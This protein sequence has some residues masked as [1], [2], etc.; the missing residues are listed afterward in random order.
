M[1]QDKLESWF[2]H[3]KDT[4]EN[5]Y[6]SS[7]EPWK[8][9]GF[10]GPLERWVACR[11]PIADCVDSSGSFLDIGCANGYLLESVLGWTKHRGISIVPYGI[12]LSQRLVE[13]ARERLTEYRNNICV[14]N[15]LLWDPPRKFDYVRTELCYVPDEFQ[16]KFVIRL[17]DEFLSKNGKLLVAEYRSR[18]DEREIGT[19]FFSPRAV[20][21]L[22]KLNPECGRGRS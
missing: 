19:M 3:L 1:N 22:W 15:G 4:L 6:L 12:D 17:V 20:L 2:S 11:K 13:L 8:Q 16:K 21:P 7:D 18:K 10:S 5:V 14:G 9:S